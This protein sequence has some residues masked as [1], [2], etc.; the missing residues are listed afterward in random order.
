MLF[1]IYIYTEEICK[2]KSQCVLWE[3][4][5][6]LFETVYSRPQTTFFLYACN[7]SILFP[8]QVNT[9]LLT[10]DLDFFYSKHF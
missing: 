3:I 1:H 9:K 2:I 7:R 4:F 10:N 8:K 6:L 5:T